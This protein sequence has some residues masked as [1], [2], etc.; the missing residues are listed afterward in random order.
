MGKLF[1]TDGVRGVINKELTPELALKL[2]KAV[3]TFF[4]RGSKLLVGRDARAGGDMLVKA[5]EAGLL[6]V[7]VKGCKSVRW[8]IGSNPSTSICSKDIRL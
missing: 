1:G 5:V 7:G 8:G 4:G 2:G 3:G 6:S